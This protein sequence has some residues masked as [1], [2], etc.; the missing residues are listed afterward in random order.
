[1][2]YVGDDVKS[3]E[4]AAL[5]MLIQFPLQLTK[6]SPQPTVPTGWGRWT[7]WQF[8]DGDSGPFPHTVTGIGNC[9]RSVFNGSVQDL[10]AFIAQ[11][12]G[13]K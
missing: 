13:T 4:Q 2:V 1:M 10:N 11:S 12:H 6:Y 3:F 9:R 7:F 8:T 5:S